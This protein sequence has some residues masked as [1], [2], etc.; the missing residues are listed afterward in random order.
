M[1][2]RRTRPPDTGTQTSLPVATGTGPSTDQ[3]RLKHSSGL[4]EH[5]ASRWS[6]PARIR[7]IRVVSA[8]RLCCVQLETAPAGGVRAASWPT[9]GWL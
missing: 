8:G 4:G 7:L 1:S 9:D 3:A 5:V 6:H 2:R